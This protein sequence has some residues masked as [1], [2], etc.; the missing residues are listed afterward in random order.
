MFMTRPKTCCCLV[1]IFIGI[2]ILCFFQ[3]FMS[4]FAL[5]QIFSIFNG[6]KYQTNEEILW[7][8]FYCMCAAPIILGGYYYFRW[9]LNKSQTKRAML[10]RAH[11]LNIV[12]I[13]M[14]LLLLIIFGYVVNGKPMMYGGGSNDSSEAATWVSNLVIVAVIIM[15]NWYWMGITA[16]Y[17]FF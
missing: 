16:R 5:Y 1:P 11:F 3:I 17:A 2:L 4:V 12:S 7:I 14:Q 15:L 10:P 9:L 6:G 13:I 8:I